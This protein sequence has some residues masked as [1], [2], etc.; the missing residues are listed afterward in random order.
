MPSDYDDVTETMKQLTRQLSADDAVFSIMGCIA[1]VSDEFTGGHSALVTAA[2]QKLYSKLKGTTTVKKGPIPNPW[3]V[4]NGHEDRSNPITTKYKKTRSYKSVGGSV[5]SVVGHVASSHTGGINVVTTA[6]HA[7]ATGTTAVHMMKI[8]AIAKAHK[9]SRTIADWCELVL[10]LKT[11]K[12]AVRGGQLVGGLIPGGALPS[13]VFASI[14]K[15]GVKLTFTNAVY[16]AA[17]GIHWR[18]FQEQ[19]ISGGRGMGTGRKIGPGSQ[20]FYEIFT[21]RSMTRLLGNYDI[22]GL[23]QEPGGWEA[24]ADKILLI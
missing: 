16:M 2:G 23:I 17:A 13:S 18:A 1:S 9:E 12:L 5:G 14:A 4:F 10:A 22:D 8:V 24:L 3:F 15:T 11:A 19:A 6:M 20:I 21:K 7:S